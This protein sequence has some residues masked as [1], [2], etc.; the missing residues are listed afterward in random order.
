MSLS[1][2]YSLV[3]FSALLILPAFAS[4]WGPEGHRIIGVDALN[5][6]DDKARSAIVEILGGESPA[7]LDEACSWPDSV[8]KTPAWEWSAPLHFVNIPRTSAHFDRQRDCPDGMCITD[9]IARY[10]NELVRPDLGP[11]RRWQALAW[12]CHLAG[13]LHQPLHAGYKDDRGGNYVEI[14]YR[15]ETENLHQFWDRVLIRSRLGANDT[16]TRPCKEH[17]HSDMPMVLKVVEFASWTDE[18]HEIAGTSAYPPGRII[19]E[20]FA[21]QSWLII[22]QQW[23][24]ASWRLARILNATLGNGAV[25]PEQ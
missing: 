3:I 25:Q 14:E 19:D 9:A 20:V 11:E 7:I 18:S 4:A 10:A 12:V 21:D 6:L 23:Q 22:R 2:F 16:W 13:D 24:K 5:L 17:D 1:G 15:G 8:R